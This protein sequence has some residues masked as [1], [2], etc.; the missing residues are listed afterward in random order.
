MK[1]SILK[2][3]NGAQGKALNEGEKRERERERE[4]ERAREGARNQQEDCRR[5]EW[6]TKTGGKAQKTGERFIDVCMHE[7]SDGMGWVY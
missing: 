3:S 1:Q 6:H 4:R 2:G 7:Q 5:N